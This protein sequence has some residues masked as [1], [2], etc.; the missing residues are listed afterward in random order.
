MRLA[1]PR[2]RANWPNRTVAEARLEARRWQNDVRDGIDPLAKRIALRH[3]IPPR[4][5]EPGRLL[6]LSAILRLP[7]NIPL[8]DDRQ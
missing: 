3:G 7:A 6:P 5:V 2:W 1:K 8:L 4:V